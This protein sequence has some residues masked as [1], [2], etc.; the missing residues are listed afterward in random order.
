MTV[1][2]TGGERKPVGN[3]LGQGR[4]QA[5]EVGMGKVRDLVNKL[6]VG[7]GGGVRTG[8][9]GGIDLIAVANTNQVVAVSADIAKVQREVVGEGVLHTQVIIRDEGGAEMRIHRQ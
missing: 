6:Q 9:R 2:V 8:A 5:I 1:G 3:P 7:E 4:L